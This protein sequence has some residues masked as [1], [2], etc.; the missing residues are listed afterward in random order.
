MLGQPISMLV[1][2]VVGLRLDG[3]LPEGA[4]ATDLV[5]TIAELLRHH[6]VV[7]Q[8]RR[9]LRP[10]RGQRPAREPGDDRQH[11]AGVRLDRHHLPDRRT[12]RCATSSSPVAP[13]EQVALVEAYAKE[14]GL[15]HDPARE[16]VFSER[17]ELD[18]VDR[19][20]Q[21]RRPRPPPGPRG[22]R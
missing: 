5:L 7:G 15:W 9:V 20:A 11:V 3:E 22:A 13:P 16:P 1:P 2:R 6:G 21:P 18:L 10:R 19:R 17:L 12:R 14:Q 4:T 8:V